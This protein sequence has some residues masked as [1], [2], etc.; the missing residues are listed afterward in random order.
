MPYNQ[1]VPVEAW[2][3]GSASQRGAAGLA[4]PGMWWGVTSCFCCPQFQGSLQARF[5][6]RSG[7]SSQGP[8]LWSSRS[9]PSGPKQPPAGGRAGPWQAAWRGQR[10]AGGLTREHG[11]TEQRS[12]EPNMDGGLGGAPPTKREKT[13]VLLNWSSYGYFI[14]S[15]FTTSQATLLIISCLKSKMPES[16]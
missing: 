13:E 7:P 12:R 11:A 6:S 15:L 10:P 14:S 3:L 1:H 8:R 2:P 4:G 5:S 9:R 16:W